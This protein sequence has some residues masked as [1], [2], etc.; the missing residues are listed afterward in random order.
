VEA[1]PVYRLRQMLSA[2]HPLTDAQWQ[3]FRTQLRV[4]H[5]EKNS[6]FLRAG[7][8]SCDLAFICS[9]L[10]RMYYLTPQGVEFNRSFALENHFYGAYR[11]ALL[12]EPAMF[13]IQA[14]EP[15]E[16]L[17]F[18]YQFINQDPLWQPFAYVFAQQ[19]LLVKEKR[20]AQFLLLT[21]EQRYQAFLE[22]Y[23]TLASRLSDRH[24]AS[25]LGITAVSLSR[26]KQKH[27]HRH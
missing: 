26:I 5:L 20:E 22:D 2:I 4:R 18:D 12:Q 27:K 7:D 24:I 10:M 9:G 14:L 21:P 1:E 15:T 16:L 13:S 23:P 19:L 25:Y 6:Y 3:L 17:L 11:S 8:I